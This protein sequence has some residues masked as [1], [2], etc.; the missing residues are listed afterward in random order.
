MPKKPVLKTTLIV[1]AAIVG[2]FL[3][4]VALQPSEFRVVRSVTITAP[5]DAV[6]PHV[7]ELKKWDA[8][9]PWAKLDPNAKNTFE[10][11]AA[12]VGAAMSWV[13]NSD[14]GE[15]RMTI[16]ESRPAELVR[17][18]LEFYKPMA[19]TSDAEFTFKAQGNQTAITWAMTGKNNFI[20]KALCLFMSMDKMVGGQ[21]ERGLAS[22]KAIA[23]GGTKK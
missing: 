20:A 23:E 11:P 7:N 2:V 1:I 5:P 8:W 21:F 6:F 19:G 16:T 18:R 12:G 9:S 22:M 17:F 3:I 10:G 13:G 14:V 4:V 15:G